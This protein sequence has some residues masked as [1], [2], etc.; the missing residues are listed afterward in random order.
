MSAT[1]GNGHYTINYHINS[2]Y[3]PVTARDVDVLATPQEIHAFTSRGYL[4]R[5]R[6]FQDEALDGMR[7][8]LDEVEQ[9]ELAKPESGVSTMGGF[10]GLFI[11]HLM[12][13]HVA[14]RDMLKFQPLLSVARAMLGPMVQIRG[15]SARIAYPEHPNQGTQW[16]IHQQVIPDPLPPFFSHPHG[17]DCLIYL[18]DIDDDNGPLCLLPGTHLQPFFS[19]PNND[20]EDK[21][22]QVELKVP[23]GTAVIV[24]SNLWHLAKGMR[25]GGRKRRL[26]IVTYTPTWLRAAPYGVKPQDGLLR[27]LEQSKDPETRELLG[28]GGYT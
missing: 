19:L 28:L 6:L 27:E 18:D 8:A 24:H 26:I 25:P 21:P 2:Q 13:K 3:L 20:F 5:E 7:G 9:R 22:G 23:A 14:F 12:D 11:R 4:V 15:F 10:G 17:L 1:N 16:H